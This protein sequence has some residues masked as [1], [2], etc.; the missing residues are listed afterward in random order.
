MNVRPSKVWDTCLKATVYR[1]INFYEKRHQFCAG[2]PEDMRTYVQALRPKTIA[3][4]VIH[5]T[6]VAHKIFKPKNPPKGD[7]ENERENGSL[8][9]RSSAKKQASKKTYQ[10]TNHLTHEEMERYQ[11][12]NRCYRCETTVYL[13]RMCKAQCTAR[14][15]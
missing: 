11:K 12:E 5:Y 3:A 13:S 10:G 8:N 2:L 15:S 9:A 7:K 1:T 14:D 4:A 6:R